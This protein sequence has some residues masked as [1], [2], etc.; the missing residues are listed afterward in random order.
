VLARLIVDRIDH[1]PGRHG[2]LAARAT[3][4]R[5]MQSNPSPGLA[6]WARILAGS[7]EEIRS[8]LLRE[9]AEGQRLRQD[10]PFCG[11]LKP[12]E[13]WAVYRRFKRE[14]AAA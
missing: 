9:D 3:C 5:W 11:V 10:S 2:L 13:R 8:V 6:E 7:W 14:S 4:H 1:D 12:Q